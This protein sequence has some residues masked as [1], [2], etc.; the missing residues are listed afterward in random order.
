MKEGSKKK[1][2]KKQNRKN[3]RKMKK[4]KANLWLQIK[5]KKMMRK[6]DKE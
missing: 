5:K 3:P 4:R 2:K 1:N 6:N